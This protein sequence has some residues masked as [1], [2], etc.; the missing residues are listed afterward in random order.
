MTSKSQSDAPAL[1]FDPYL[2]I[3]EVA[4]VLRASRPTIY[5]LIDAGD[6]Q[7]IRFGARNVRVAASSLTRFL[8]RARVQCQVVA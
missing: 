8:Q 7:A 6:L 5:D 3:G 1:V 2:K 4:R